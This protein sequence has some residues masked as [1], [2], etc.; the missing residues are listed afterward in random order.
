M[1]ENQTFSDIFS[2]YGNGTLE[3]WNT[4]TFTC[5]EARTSILVFFYFE[6]IFGFHLA[7]EHHGE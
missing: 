6:H 4:V 5:K 3:Q 2:G 1:S 7:G